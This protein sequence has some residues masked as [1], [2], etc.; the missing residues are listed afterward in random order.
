MEESPVLEKAVRVKMALL[1]KCL[2]NIGYPKYLSKLTGLKKIYTS[3]FRYID[4]DIIYPTGGRKQIQ[5]EIKSNHEKHISHILS[6]IKRESKKFVELTASL[7]RI[8]FKEKTSKELNEFFNEYIDSFTKVYTLLMMPLEIEAVLT[9]LIEK[10]LEKKIDSEKDFSKFKRCFNAIAIASDKTE[11][12]KEKEDLLKLAINIKKK[13]LDGLFKGEAKDIKK[14]LLEHKELLKKIDEHKD[15]YAWTGIRFLSGNPLEIDDFIIKLREILKKKP[16]EE[17]RKLEDLRKK[18]VNEF[19]NAI[20]ELNPNKEFSQLIEFIKE[21]V[22]LRTN[23][24]E[25]INKGNYYARPLLEEIAKQMNFTYD[26]V[27]YLF[28]NE[29]NAFLEKNKS[30][31]IDGIKERQEGYALIEEEEGTKL[32]VGRELEKIK[33][34]IEKEFEEVEEIKGHTASQGKAKGI[35]KIVHD[36]SELGKVEKGDILVTVMTTPDFVVAMEKAS[37]VVTD[38]GGVTSHAAIMSREL[39]IPC[40]IG[41]EKAT[42]VL[43]DGDLVEVNANEGIVKVIQRK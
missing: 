31:D 38:I 3:N 34:E 27:T 21:T 10:E 42:K 40:I 16:E 2:A 18:E 9:E 8:D 12:I 23:R 25:S 32:Y 17:L 7:N 43:K 5:E 35:V 33:K 13:E 14:S 26:N 1:A 36:P 11:T 29:I 22:F 28:P 37:A 6:A 24:L 15:K 4:G 41:T 30:P 20:R 39:G 19:E